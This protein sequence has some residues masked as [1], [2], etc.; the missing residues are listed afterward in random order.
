MSYYFVM[1]TEYDNIVSIIEGVRYN[2][3]SDKIKQIVIN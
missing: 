2:V 3:D 1:K